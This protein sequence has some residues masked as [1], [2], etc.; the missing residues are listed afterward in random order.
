[1]E[2]AEV[3]ASLVETCPSMDE[4]LFT[5]VQTDKKRET[6]HRDVELCVNDHTHVAD[7]M[8]GDYA[9]SS[10][11]WSTSL[12]ESVREQAEHLRNCPSLQNESAGVMQ[13]AL[14]TRIP[15]QV[16][17]KYRVTNMSVKYI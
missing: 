14:G 7:R 17:N 2:Y 5:H 11:C 13:R 8:V 15:E 12:S 3:A 10:S 1:M 9:L 16:Q 6:P 4:R